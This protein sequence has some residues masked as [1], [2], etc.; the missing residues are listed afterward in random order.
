MGITEW[1]PGTLDL[2]TAFRE[3][4]GVTGASILKEYD[5]HPRDRE[6]IREAVLGDE[7]AGGQLVVLKGGCL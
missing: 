4:D 5:F 6:T 7:R 1:L 3:R 2:P